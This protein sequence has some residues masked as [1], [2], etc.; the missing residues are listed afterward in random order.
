MFARDR[1]IGYVVERFTHEGETEQSVHNVMYWAGYG[2]V[3]PSRITTNGDI[4]IVAE[5]IKS[6][7][8]YIEKNTKD[9]KGSVTECDVFVLDGDDYSSIHYE[10]M[11][12]EEIVAKLQS[13]IELWKGE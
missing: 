6:L 12:V 13:A 1:T 3:M 8:F 2:T 9:L 7:P 10:A 5:W 11:T 4:H